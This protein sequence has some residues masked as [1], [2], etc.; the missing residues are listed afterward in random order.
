MSI[1]QKLAFNQSGT[2][3]NRP[4]SEDY[5]DIVR[6]M[7]EASHQNTIFD[8]IECTIPNMAGWCSVEKAK[9]MAML[10]MA[11]KPKVCVEIGVFA[12]RSTIPVA[13]ALKENGGGKLIAIDAWSAMASIENETEQNR[14]WW[15]KRVDYQAI[16]KAFL[17]SI[18]LAGVSYYVSAFKLKSDSF[19]PPVRIDFLHI[20]GSHTIQA[21]K[22][23]ERFACKVPVHG[24]VVMDDLDWDGG[25]VL[26]ALEKLKEMGFQELFK[27]GTG[28][29]YQRIK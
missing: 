17:N 21:V 29:V 5:D 9:T 7:K 18:E 11:M 15:G 2:I 13:M 3:M 24:I 22:D 28:A 26:K 27:L 20:D 14:E 1:L 19:D 12:G 6:V 4:A 25:G 10:V 16:Y 8:R 23:V